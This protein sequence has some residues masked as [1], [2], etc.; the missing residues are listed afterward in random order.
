[1]YRSL[2]DETGRK[3]YQNGSN[4]STIILDFYG[5]FPTYTPT[6]YVEQPHF[7]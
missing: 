2:V 5:L 3:K 1:M 6:D 7:G 4:G